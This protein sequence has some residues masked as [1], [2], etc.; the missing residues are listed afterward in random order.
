[1]LVDF[2]IFLFK[3]FKNNEVFDD[4]YKIVDVNFDQF[5]FFN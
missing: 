4:Q 3:I 1:M 5:E 2:Q